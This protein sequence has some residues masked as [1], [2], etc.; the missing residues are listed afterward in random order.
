MA[1][2]AATF[3]LSTV[4]CSP[5]VYPRPWERMAVP[6]SCSSVPVNVPLWDQFPLCTRIVPKLRDPFCDQLPP[7]A[8]RSLAVSPPVS[9]TTALLALS[10]G[11]VTGSV[12]VRPTRAPLI[13][14]LLTA[15]TPTLSGTDSYSRT[16]GPSFT[17]TPSFT[18]TMT[19]SVTDTPVPSS[20]AARDS[21]KDSRNDLQAA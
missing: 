13:V 15:P 1:A 2:F 3:T 21:E 11:K 17:A 14:R 4:I 8:A 5:F 6:R 10:Q 7:T 16:L 9:V 19:F 12:K 18:I 20:S